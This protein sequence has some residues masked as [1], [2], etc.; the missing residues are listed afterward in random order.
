LN[1][2][3]DE[4]GMMN[5][6]SI[7]NKIIGEQ[8]DKGIAP[9]RVIVGGFSQGSVIAFLVLLTLRIYTPMCIPS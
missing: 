6:V 4:A 1:A 8:I 5:S 3:D 9:E 7:I 2:V